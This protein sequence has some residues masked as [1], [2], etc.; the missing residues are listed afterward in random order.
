MEG[1][2]ED[3]RRHGFELPHNSY[4]ILSWGIFGSDIIFYFTIYMNVFD[5]STRVIFTIS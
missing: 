5:E 4:Q 1:E 3:V 2:D